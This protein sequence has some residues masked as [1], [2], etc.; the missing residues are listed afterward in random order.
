MLDK[1]SKGLLAVCC[2]VIFL[3]PA[4]LP[5]V[6]ADADVSAAA[7]PVTT[8]PVTV[9]SFKQLAI[10]PVVHVPASVVSLNNS[11]LSAEVSAI[12]T[13]IVVDVGQTV[14]RG[15]VLLILDSSYY[16]LEYDRSNAALQSI[17][18]KRDLAN[19]QLQRAK[20]LS[21]QKVVSEELLAQ[22]ESDLKALAGEVKVQKA[23]RDIAK[24]NLDRCTVKAPF[25]AIIKERL[26]HIG[27]LARIGTPLVHI[28]DAEKLEISAKIQTNDIVSLRSAKKIELVSQGG[29]YNIELKNITPAYD[30]FERSQEVRFSFSD[31]DKVDLPGAFGKVIWGKATPHIPADIMV[32]RD[33]NLG[34]FIVKG[35][36]SQ[37]VSLSNAKEGQPVAQSQLSEDVPIVVDG[38]YRLQDGNS[39]K[40]KQ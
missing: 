29:R 3:Q 4:S 9:K 6:V 27:E 15:S 33:G 35:N 19:Y 8:I 21:K 5:L 14:N 25:K 28:V 30:S 17:K 2:A 13:D 18:A 38:R 20:S 10:Y 39:V 31:T 12:I 7:I 37:F 32:R 24:R 11:K 1:F 36:K 22:R 34:I 40:I 23:L 16:Q 26:G